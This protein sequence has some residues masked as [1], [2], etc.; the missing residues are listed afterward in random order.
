METIDFKGFSHVK[1][2]IKDIDLFLSS[3]SPDK[4]IYPPHH[5]RYYAL[6]VTP[7]DK[8]KVVILGQDPYHQ[9]GQAHGLAFSTLSHTIPKSLQNIFKAVSL[10]EPKVNSKDGNLT[11]WAKQG[12]L[13]W[14]VYLSVEKSKPL[15]HAIKSYETLTQYLMEY[16]SKT[17]THVVFLLWG[18]FAQTFK[19][20]IHG[21]H[22]IIESPHPSPLSVYRGFYE[23]DI[24]EKTNAYLL[25]HKKSP[26]D[27]R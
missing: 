14:N 4:I 2:V 7:L 8:V 9:E 3:L 21:E 16:I 22:L 19:S 17:H 27:W 15:S 11:R 20:F 24:F 1:E 25:K 23:M 12:V 13:L 10:Y 18:S 26:I 5:M 6:E